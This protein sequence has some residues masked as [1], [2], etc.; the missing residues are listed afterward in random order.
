M[1][2]F[3]DDWPHGV[4]RLAFISL[5]SD[6]NVDEHAESALGLLAQ[7]GVKATW[8]LLEPGY[9]DRDLYSRIRGEGHELGFHYN[10]LR[11]QGGRWGA[12]EFARQ[13]IW[14]RGAAGGFK[15]VSN[16]NHYTRFE[17]WGELFRWCE[18]HGIAVDQTR[19]PSKGGNVGFLFGTCHPFFPLA[20]ADE[21]NRFYDVLE[22]GFL[23]QDT[24][25]GAP[26][27][28]SS[29]V[30]PLLD[31]VRSVDG[32][33]HFLFH[34]QHIHTKPSVVA[35][36]RKTVDAARARGFTFRTSKE[37]SDWERSRRRL[38]IEGL[39]EKGKVRLSE[40]PAADT[41]V[42]WLPAVSKITPMGASTDARPPGQDVEIRF[43]LPCVRQTPES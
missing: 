18:A 42:I 43:G 31:Q 8:C 34:P 17:G 10:A 6:G 27:A 25:I 20:W 14:F 21:R 5:D 12:E 1:L 9:T 4:E 32:V 29:I 11:D 28:D 24:D 40:T 19:G 38:R 3:V 35:S 13:L 22:L 2:P 39:D 41:P 33:A 16:K 30:E 37:I 7:T 15:A 26:W 36:F 23:T